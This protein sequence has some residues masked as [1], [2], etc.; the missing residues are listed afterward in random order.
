M[1]RFYTRVSVSCPIL[2]CV[3][4]ISLSSTCCAMIKA[5]GGKK[6]KKKISTFTRLRFCLIF[7]LVFSAVPGWYQVPM[8]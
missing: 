6:K 4:L 3:R 8:S 7:L 5:V 1:A 2:F